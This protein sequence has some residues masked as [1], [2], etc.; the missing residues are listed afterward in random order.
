MLLLAAT[1]LSHV[2]ATGLAVV[3][4]LA[5]AR[6]RRDLAPLAGTWVAAFLVAG[7]WT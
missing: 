6:G 7:W 4:S 3:G 2:M 1:A 5:L